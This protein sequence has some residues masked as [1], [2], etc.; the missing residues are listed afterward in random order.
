M[1]EQDIYTYRKLPWLSKSTILAYRFCQHLFDLRYNKG[2]DTGSTVKA[3]TGTNMHILY[4]KFFDLID[5]T[6]LMNIVIDYEK[7]LNDTAVYQYFYKI[8]MELIPPKSRTYK[9]YQWMVKNFALLETDDWINLNRI[10][11]GKMPKILKYFKP[12]YIEKFLE[13]E[14]LMLYGTV[15]RM[16]WF[17]D[18]KDMKIMYDYKT[19]RVPAD[20]K[21]GPK[22]SDPFSWTLPT[23]KNFEMHFYLTL[24]M[25]RMGFHLHQDIVDYC[26]LPKHF[27]EDVPK[28]DSYFY[29]KNER[30][31]DV[32]D[33]YRVGF[34]F[35]GDEDMPYVPKKKPSKR[36][37]TS[38]FKW[39]NKIRGIIHDG[40][41][42]IK[43]PSF[44]KCRECNETIRDKCLTEEEEKM[45]FWTKNDE[46]SNSE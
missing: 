22:S 16:G 38:V 41:P 28:V 44:W 18:M 23:K 46:G 14:D 30:P 33:Y 35:S 21:K 10:H 27:G 12:L 25:Y 5:Y 3:E 39:I 42:Y 1:I 37:F 34:V 17:A 20:V 29:D 8:L 24:E 9:P 43:E 6:V 26:T 4:A 32:G 31:V 2:M 45:I 7:D 13:C 19:G 15:D 36:S 11:K 40:G